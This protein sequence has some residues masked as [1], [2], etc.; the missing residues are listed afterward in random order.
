MSKARQ[1]TSAYIKSMRLYYGF[2]TG[3][4]GWIGVSFRQFLGLEGQVAG[5]AVVV[6]AILFLSWGIN[7]IINDYLGLAEDRVNAPHRP[8]V[9]GALAPRPALLLSAGLMV[10]VAGVTCLLNPWAV[11]PL[12]AGVLLNVLY[13]H[14]KAW[15]LLGNAVFGVSIAMCAA[16]GFLAMGPLPTPLFTSN[17]ISVFVLLVLL[18][19]LMTYYTYFKDYHGDKAAGKDTFVVRH[20]LKT[21]RYVG[22]G[23]ALLPPVALAVVIAMGWIPAHEILY[24]R[25]FIFCGVVTMFLLAWTAWLFF[26]HPTGDRT[27]FAL[28]TNI[29]AC[30]AGQITL[31]AIFDGTL[32]LYLLCASYVLIGFL[33]NLYPDPKS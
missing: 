26:V 25:D 23:A 9:T 27:Y 7:Q 1:F 21:A 19:G 24:T 5:R 14:A 31:I 22:L 10:L 30:V 33:F 12:V 3:I 4:T 11:I 28:V 32:A 20:G 8:M 15:S 6:L 13:E 17:R 2:I 18:N 29:R 16:Y